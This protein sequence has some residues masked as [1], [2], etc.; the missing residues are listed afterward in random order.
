MSFQMVSPLLQCADDCEHFLVI[1]FVVA[2]S[3][4]ERPRME[5]D[6]PEDV[7]GFDSVDLGEDTSDGVIR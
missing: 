1:N 7:V 2:L 4:E 3:R 5:G 6:G